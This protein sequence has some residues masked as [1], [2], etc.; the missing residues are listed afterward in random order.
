[1]TK[2]ERSKD[3]A[4]RCAIYTR[5]STQDGLEQ[6]FNTLDAQRET[7]WRDPTCT[8]ASPKNPFGV[9]TAVLSQPDGGKYGV[10]VEGAPG[11]QFNVAVYAYDQAGK[12][13]SVIDPNQSA[14][15]ACAAVG[16]R[17]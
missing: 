2:A 6:E 4:V 9:Q 16:T 1:M 7:A 11:S 3:P 14:A 15:G 13:S 8:A 10:E 5:K 17:W 12:L